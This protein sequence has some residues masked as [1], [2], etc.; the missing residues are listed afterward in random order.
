MG[1]RARRAIASVGILAFL[2][3]YVWGVIAIG[4]HVPD[5]PVVT[6]LFYGLA[7]TL[8]GVPLLP[9][10]SWAEGKPFLKKR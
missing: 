1:L 6:L 9:L 10:M 2:V 7:G 3:L 5:H 4:A 8:W